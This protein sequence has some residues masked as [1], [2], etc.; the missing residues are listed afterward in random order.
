MNTVHITSV[1][2]SRYRRDSEALNEWIDQVKEHLHTW[3]DDVISGDQ[4][5]DHCIAY[6]KQFTVSLNI[7]G[8]N[9]TL[10]K[11]VRKTTQST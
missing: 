6:Y 4:E 7:Y 11:I 9:C 3:E 10:F 1:Y 8:I 5:T 2:F